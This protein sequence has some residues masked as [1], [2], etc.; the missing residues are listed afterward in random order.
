VGGR[1][2]KRFTCRFCGVILPA[3]LPVAQEPYG[4]MPL[5]HLGRQ[6]PREVGA[7]LGQMR[8]TKDIAPMAA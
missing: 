7:F 8:T 5:G 1:M 4:A 2:S 3:W 6:H